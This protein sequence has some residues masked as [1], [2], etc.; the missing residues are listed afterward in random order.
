METKKREPSP[1]PLIL[2]GDRATALVTSRNASSVP[3][4]SS[5]KEAEL[6]ELFEDVGYETSEPPRRP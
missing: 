4:L 6:E 5:E 1:H 3:V 2:L